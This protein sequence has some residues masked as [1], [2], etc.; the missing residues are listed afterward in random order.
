MK[1]F[2]LLALTAATVA[3]LTGC[4]TPMSTGPMSF[5]VTSVGSG[6][7]ADLGG[8][9]GAD[10]HCQ[11]LAGAANAGG[12]PVPSPRPPVMERAFSPPC[13][14]APVSWGDASGCHR[15][16]LQA[17]PSRRIFPPG[18]LLFPPDNPLFPPDP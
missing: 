11:R 9:A 1:K 6:R 17:S 14:D 13:P 18:S 2:R 3:L 16:A 4:A 15:S 7:G 10:A 5:F 8:L 12:K